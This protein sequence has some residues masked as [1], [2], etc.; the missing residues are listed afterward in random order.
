V[1]IRLYL[2]P[3]VVQPVA[4]DLGMDGADKVVRPAVLVDLARVPLVAP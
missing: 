2:L 1:D 4:G 3:S